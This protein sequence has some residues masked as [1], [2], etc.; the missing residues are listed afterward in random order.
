MCRKTRTT[1]N[2]TW[3]DKIMKTKLTIAGLTLLAA[4]TVEASLTY[5]PATF[6]GVIPDG[7][8]SGIASSITVS[9]A[10]INVVRDVNVTLEISGGYNG[11]LYGYLVGPDGGMAVLLNRIGRTGSALFGS[12][13]GGMNLIINDDAM[14]SNGNLHGAGNTVLGGNWVSD[15]RLEDPLTVTDAAA[16]TARLNQVFAE[17][18]GH[19]VN[20]TWTLF[21]ADMAGGDVS[22]LVSWGL[23]ITVVPEPV[24]WA[25]LV[26]GGLVTAGVVR[27]QFQIRGLAK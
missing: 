2:Q 26:F 15:G 17:G 11:D 20:G 12:S 1:N 14:V 13:G 8:A 9:G 6:T 16:V 7:S 4:I 3:K 18:N 27:R 23:D 22:T 10:G 5:G 21:L 24:T 19:A 25:L